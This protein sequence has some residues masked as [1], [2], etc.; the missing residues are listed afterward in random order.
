MTREIPMEDLIKK[1]DGIE[2][3]LTELKGIAAERE[4]VIAYITSQIR[5]KASVYNGKIK[6]Y[7][8]MRIMYKTKLEKFFELKTLIESYKED[9]KRAL[10]N[11]YRKELVALTDKLNGVE[12]AFKVNIFKKFDLIKM[13]QCDKFPIL[14]QKKQKYFTEIQYDLKIKL[15]DKVKENLGDKSTFNEA[16]FYINFIVKYERYFDEVIFTDLLFSIITE[17]FNYHFLSDRDSNRLDKLEWVFEFLLHKYEELEIIFK[18]YGTCSQ[19]A[20][21]LQGGYSELIN[22]TENLIDLKLDELSRSRS[23]QKKKLVLHF[24]TEFIKFGKKVKQIYGNEIGGDSLACMLNDIQNGFIRNELS[25]IH[26]MS[27]LQW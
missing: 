27:Y 18:I 9:N 12:L 15:F 13:I 25:R 11:E 3:K 23:N 8:E 7:K 6:E 21:G 14:Q 17:K 5:S 24:G 26:E 1:K 16:I 4:F 19:N 20:G 10:K 2:S 22:K